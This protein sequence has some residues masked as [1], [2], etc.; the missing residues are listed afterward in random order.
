M[1]KGEE[2]KNKLKEILSSNEDLQR[3]MESEKWTLLYN[4]RS[5]TVLMGAGFPDGSFYYPVVFKNEDTGVAL[6]IDK[7]NKIYGLAIENAKYFIR[8]HKSESIAVA[9]SFLI[10]P[11]TSY[12][13]KLPSYFVAYH[14]L[15]GIHNIKAIFNTT[16]DYVAGK[17]AYC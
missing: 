7:N 14:T 3:R 9:L 8:R 11:K 1:K 12:L 17:A 16:S 2:Q 10:Y 5:D 13:I 4:K 6:R 15:R